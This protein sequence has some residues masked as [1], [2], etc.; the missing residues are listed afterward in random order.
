VQFMDFVAVRAVLG[1]RGLAV[2]RQYSF[3]FPRWAGRL[4]V[5]NEFVS[6]GRLPAAPARAR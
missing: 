6:V 3:P 4:F 5:Y 2:E 1:E